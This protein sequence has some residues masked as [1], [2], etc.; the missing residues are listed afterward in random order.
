[1]AKVIIHLNLYFMEKWH[2]IKRLVIFFLYLG[3]FSCQD[4]DLEMENVISGLNPVGKTFV[5]CLKRSPEWQ[6]NWRIASQKGKILFNEAAL[7]YG[8]GYDWHYVLPLEVKGVVFGLVIFPLE[9]IPEDG[10]SGEIR[11]GK[12]TVRIGEEIMEDPGAAGFLNTRSFAKWK[13]QGLKIS[14]TLDKIRKNWGGNALGNIIKTRSS[15][16]FICFYQLEFENYLDGDGFAVIVGMAPSDVERVFYGVLASLPVKFDIMVDKE[17][18]YIYYCKEEVVREYLRQ[19]GWAFWRQQV[20]FT[21]LYLSGTNCNGDSIDEYAD[22]GGGGSGGGSSGSGATGGGGSY[23]DGEIIDPTWPDSVRYSKIREIVFRVSGIQTGERAAVK[24]GMTDEMYYVPL[25]EAELIGTDEN[26]QTLTSFYEVIRFG[27]KSVNDVATVVGLAEEKIY[28]V[29]AFLGGKYGSEVNGDAWQIYDN[30]LIHIGPK[31][32][33]GG[34]N[35]Y[36][37]IEIC[38][39]K[40]ADFN[41]KVW[42]YSNTTIGNDLV[43]S[44]KFKVYMMKAQKPALIPQN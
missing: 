24:I 19:V 5:D 37:C 27:V 35:A 10:N 34:V 18:A 38:H 22:S 14:E 30:F 13:E 1:M 41:Q 12:P 42:Q 39:S 6:E 26:G 17:Y 28:T 2:F 11:L 7:L 23:G 3:I 15:G 21:V 31:D 29:Q 8:G 4:D 33:E 40:M 36:G 43:A 20:Y 16:D 9:N 44:G 25:Y 32:L